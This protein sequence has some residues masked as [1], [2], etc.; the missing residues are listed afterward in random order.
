MRSLHDT[1]LDPS[2]LVLKKGLSAEI[3]RLS[4]RVLH[5]EQQLAQ[6]LKDHTLTISDTPTG[7][8]S[9]GDWREQHNLLMISLQISDGQAV[10]L[11]DMLTKDVLARQDLI[12]QFGAGNVRAAM[13]RL[14]EALV[15]YDIKLS[16]QYGVGYWLA[17]ED[18]QKIYARMHAL[19]G[20]TELLKEAT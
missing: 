18:K 14:R 8:D 3:N 11:L 15:K 13:H 20:S 12:D 17:P 6:L 9:F 5:L 19:R 7:I 4:V 1:S 16:S 10:L 2:E